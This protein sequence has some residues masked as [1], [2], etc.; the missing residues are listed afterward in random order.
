MTDQDRKPN[1]QYQPKRY[2]GAE[3]TITVELTDFEAMFIANRLWESGDRYSNLGEEQIA[4]EAKL[5]ARRLHSER[6]TREEM[7]S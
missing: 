3:D 5:W 1:G 7:E 4:S 2:V 6:K